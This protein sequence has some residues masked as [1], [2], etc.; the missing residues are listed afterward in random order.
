MVWLQLFLAVLAGGGPN[1]FRRH[2]P[3][4]DRWTDAFT[5]LRI[6]QPGG[7]ADQKYPLTNQGAWRVDVQQVRVPVE[8]AGNTRGNLAA[9][10]QRGTKGLDVIREVLV[11]FAAQADIQII[12]LA[13]VPTIAAKII[14]EI[15]V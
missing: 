8:F 5:A 7:I 13:V 2:Q 15:N 14:A 12:S 10:F 3:R 11:I 4:L 1:N 9:F 6:S